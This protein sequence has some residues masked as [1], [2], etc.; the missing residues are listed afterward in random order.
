MHISLILHKVV[1]Y[2]YKRKLN[3]LL[4]IIVLTVT[5]YLLTIVVQMFY[6]SNYYVFATKQALKKDD[7]VNI[8]ILMNQQDPEGYCE[9]VKELDADLAEKYGGQYGKF[10][11][12]DSS[13]EVPDGREETV[14]TLYLDASI[15]DLCDISLVNVS[16]DKMEMNEDIRE[17]YVG[18][19]LKEQFPVGTILTDIHTGNRIEIV[20]EIKA[21]TVWLPNLLFRSN[22]AVVSLDD[23]I[24]TEMDQGYFEIS[25]AFYANTVNSV[26]I[27]CTSEKE[28]EQ[29]KQDVQERANEM[30]VMVYCYTLD[31]LIGQ[32][33]EDNRIFIKKL[34]FLILFVAI[35]SVIAYLSAGLADIYSRHYE[36]AVMYMNHVSPID[37]FLMLFVENI[38]KA[39]ISVG[40]SL[41]LYGRALVG[42]DLVV[43]Q[44]FVVPT[45]IIAVFIFMFFVT[46]LCYKTINRKKLLSMIGGTRL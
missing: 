23:Y 27:K 17:G 13:F 31:D 2:I 9:I 3:F 43:F 6:N 39:V 35:I 5:L 46:I 25:S 4:S 10:M 30:G 40:I 45:I 22:D 29:V 26:Y 16:Q 32:E 1:G 36:M 41:F 14:Q 18:E 44:A 28:V 8:H 37:I 33:K 38:I 11:Y 24:V 34:G 15:M 19:T 21:G 42:T 20:A 12:M 7:I